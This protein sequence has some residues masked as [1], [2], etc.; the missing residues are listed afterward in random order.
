MLFIINFIINIFTRLPFL[1]KVIISAIAILLI[2]SFL[3]K[4]VN[5]CEAITNR[6]KTDVTEVIPNINYKLIDPQQ[7]HHIFWTGGYDSTFRL[8]QILLQLDRPVQPIYIMCGNVDS[9]A[10]RLSKF[11]GFEIS[12]KN[13][14]QELETMKQIRNIIIKNN[15]HL[16]NKFLPT[17][18][19]ISVQKD[20]NISRAF[21]RLHTNLGYFTRSISQYERMARYSSK[22]PYP[23]EVGLEKCGTGLD[24]ATVKYRIDKGTNCRIRDDI[25][26]SDDDLRIFS[27]FRFPIA[28]LD[29][30]EMRE[31]AL[32]NNFFYI[33]KMSWSCWYPLENGSSCGKCDMCIKRI[34]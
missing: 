18:Y 34:I 30:K 15:P 4:Q 9:E 21:K 11:L 31:I 28:H 2:Q 33:L 6:I 5:K 26:L 27:K 19:V 10:T 7:T 3:N 14:K 24:E 22:Y 12:R 32:K 13:Q 17:H 29:K 1:V 23:I 8:C 20:Y 25:A 16:A